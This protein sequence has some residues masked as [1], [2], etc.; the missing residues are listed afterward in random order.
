MN[1]PN[2]PDKLVPKIKDGQRITIIGLGG[3]GGRTAKDIALL[4]AA[5]NTSVTLTLID[6]DQFEPSNATRMHFNDFGPKVEVVAR[7]LLPKFV[8]SKLT[9]ETVVEYVMPSNI[10]KLIREGDIVILALDNHSGRKL[11]SDWASTMKN[12][13]IISGGNDSVETDKGMRG[14]YGNVQ[15]Y[16]RRDGVDLTESLT[17]FH[18]EI[19]QP[20][21]KPPYEL[22]CTEKM[23]KYPQL[24]LSNIMV[25]AAILNALYLYLS[26][27]LHYSEIAIDWADGA[28]NT[29]ITLDEPI[30]H[31]TMSPCSQQS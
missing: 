17:C 8:E 11:V 27:A 23:V 31:D 29:V 12:V 26:N 9:V 4:L 19:D 1:K 6:S 15:I 28:S 7:D 18:P 21:D 24:L 2:L 5:S 10:S 22:S 13:T 30:G 16:V 14:S 20:K 3:V 25:S